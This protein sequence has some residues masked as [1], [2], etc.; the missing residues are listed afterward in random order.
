MANAARKAATLESESQTDST[1]ATK[2]NAQS[3]TDELESKSLH[4]HAVTLEEESERDAAAAEAARAS[5]VEYA[6]A[7]AE[8]E[9]QAEVREAAAVAEEA[10]YDAETE[11]ALAEAA[12]VAGLEVEAEADG[13][14]VG[15]CEFIP[16]LDV[17]CDVVGGVA[18]LEMQTSAARWTA[19]SAI[20]IISAAAAKEQQDTNLVASAASHVQ[21]EAD[22]DMATQLQNQAAEEQAR[23]EEAAAGANEEQLQADAKLTESNEEQALSEEE[24]LKAESEQAQSGRWWI[25]SLL[26]GIAAF[27]DAILGACLS[28]MAFLFFTVRVCVAVV[29]P[30]VIQITNYLPLVMM[31][32]NGRGHQISDEFFANT[33]D[34]LRQMSYFLLHCGVFFTGIITFFTKFETM[35]KLNTRSKGGVILLF[36]LFVASVQSFLLHVLSRYKTNRSEGVPLAILYLHIMWRASCVFLCGV[37][38]LV[39]LVIMETLSL[40]IIFGHSVFSPNVSQNAVPFAI[41]CLIISALAHNYYFEGEE[42]C[43]DSKASVDNIC[44]ISSGLAISDCDS[45]VQMNETHDHEKDLLLEV[46]DLDSGNIDATNTSAELDL[47]EDGRA[48]SIVSI[49]GYQSVVHDEIT[50]TTIPSG[51]IPTYHSKCATIGSEHDDEVLVASGIGSTLKQATS[52]GKHYF[53]V[54]QFPFEVLVMSCMFGLLKS[55]I[56]ICKRLWPEFCKEFIGSH[57]RLSIILILVVVSVSVGAFFWCLYHS[58]KKKSSNIHVG[59]FTGESVRTTIH[60]F[61]PYQ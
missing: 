37:A 47:D 44:D 25:K 49:S 26:C 14:A 18:G 30:S 2:N 51:N 19:Q 1:L 56:P 59:L 8:E 55:S 16:F 27:W 38:Y 45:F 35:E 34:T 58:S 9:A 53:S 5:T 6:S 4:Q 46:T 43:T 54:L 50:E 24:K 17:L 13:M 29:V 21:A 11:K 42:D 22:A 31:I 20:D 3:T 33:R 15:A 23:S 57:Q 7:A 10:V 60:S 28:F 40:W 32:P 39:P 61:L 36:A 48:L 12:E 52:A 41:L